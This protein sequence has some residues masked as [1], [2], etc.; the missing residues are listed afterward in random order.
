MKPLTKTM[1]QLIEHM[2]HEGGGFIYRHPGGFWSKAPG[3]FMRAQT[4]GTSS[5]EA[6]VSRGIAEYVEWQ[7]GRNGRFPVKAKLTQ[8]SA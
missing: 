4:F 1:Q 7:E 5:V 6:L 2:R 8:V 3:Y